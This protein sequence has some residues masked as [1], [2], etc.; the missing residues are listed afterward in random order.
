M[1]NLL[2]AASLAMVLGGVTCVHAGVDAAKATELA[3]RQACLGCHAANV[4]LV[5]PAYKDIASKYKG[6]DPVA[7][8]SS[9]RTGSQGK[10]GALQMPAQTGLS[11]ADLRLL[12]EWVLAGAPQD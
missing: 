5:G 10:W 3:T 11:D 1:R 12:A 7:L 9:I 6:M 8:A 4:A 2:K